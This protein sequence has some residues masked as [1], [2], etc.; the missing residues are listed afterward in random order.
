MRY[1]K[2]LCHWLFNSTSP[3]WYPWNFTIE[4]SN[5]KAGQ[6]HSTN[7][8][9]EGLNTL[10]TGACLT[11]NLGNIRN[12]QFLKSSDTHFVQLISCQNNGLACHY[13]FPCGYK[14][15]TMSKGLLRNHWQSAPHK[16]TAQCT[17]LAIT[18][19]LLQTQQVL[20][21]DRSV[22]RLDF[23]YEYF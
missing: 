16:F 21:E 11:V 23:L 1:G 4:A 15:I 8:A 22:N 14:A 6:V 20:R 18:I 17:E 7:L 9:W 3:S 13:T 19:L 2:A 5:F 12:T 10:A